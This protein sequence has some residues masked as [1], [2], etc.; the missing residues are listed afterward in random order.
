MWWGA[1]VATP[2]PTRYSLT[3]EYIQN[4][5]RTQ[6]RET[7]TAT[8]LNGESEAQASPAT[9]SQGQL[10]TL[11]RQLAGGGRLGTVLRLGAQ[12]CPQR[13]WRYHVRSEAAY[14]STGTP[15]WRSGNLEKRQPNI[16][17]ILI[18]ATA[19]LAGLVVLHVDECPVS[20]GE[21]RSRPLT[22]SR[23]PQG[24]IAV[25]VVHREIP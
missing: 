20:D 4:T 17:D 13:A 6:R 10:A 11:V 15:P 2:A 21:S 19:E 16:P 25:V 14:L 3:S 9:I 8:A 23:R 1:P 18:A 22:T 5:A 24:P 7:S 12:C